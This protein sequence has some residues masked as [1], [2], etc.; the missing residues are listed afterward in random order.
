MPGVMQRWPHGHRWQ[1]RLGKVDA[2]QPFDTRLGP[3]QL[4]YACADVELATKLPGE[5]VLEPTVGIHQTISSDG[6]FDLGCP[7]PDTG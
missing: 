3:W 7:N 6:A 1:Q 2:D 5:S 4:N